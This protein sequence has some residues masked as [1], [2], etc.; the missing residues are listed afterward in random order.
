MSA[1]ASWFRKHWLEAGWV[2]FTGA[3]LVA[4][5]VLHDFVTLPFHAIWVSLIVLYGLR[6]WPLRT[7][8]VIVTA[9]TCASGG[10]LGWAVAQGHVPP[11]ELHEIPLM[12]GMFAILAWHASRRQSV[13][14]RL[15]KMAH[16]ERRLR[17]LQREFVQDAS[18]ELR[19]PITIARGHG[20]L[21]KASI[22][23]GLS[24][25]DVD[26]VLE[27][28]DRLAKISERL[29][30]LAAA[31]QT[32]FL[33]VEDVE[34]R[35]L[36]SGVAQRWIPTCER[37]WSVRVTS[38]GIVRVDPERLQTA[39]DALVENAV[40]Y[41]QP[42]DSIEI[43]ASRDG[44]E[45][46]I[47]VRDTGSG[48]PPDRLARVFDRFARVDDDH[49]R[50]TGGTGLGLAIVK[51]VVEAHGGT[52]GATSEPGRGSTFDI[53]LPGFQPARASNATSSEEVSPAL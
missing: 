5:L 7:T 1:I 43:I 31:D 39:L 32:S 14:R 44:G 42:D 51:A 24:E 4:I 38:D 27:E 28:L 15:E 23:G 40:A 25:R 11:D 9:A 26:V 41:T 17:E 20:E 36:V 13:I 35:E 34:L 21:L 22:A 50:S 37:R 2:G 53:R 6:L 19:T 46:V 8:I 33:R 29:L 48:I 45:A 3:N 18:H 52:V 49:G 12:V 10:A 16:T 47:V 30:L